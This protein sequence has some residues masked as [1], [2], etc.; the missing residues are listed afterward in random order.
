MG[1]LSEILLLPL[2]PVRGTLWVAEQL[3]QEAERQACDPR[4]VRARLAALNRDLDDGLIDEAAFEAEE[5][6]L[7]ARLGDPVRHGAL[8]PHGGAR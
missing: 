5:E 1:L 2:A 8:P 3:R 6:R 7:L 4:W